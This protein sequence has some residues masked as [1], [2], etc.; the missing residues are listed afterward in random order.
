MTTWGLR[1]YDSGYKSFSGS[2]VLSPNVWTWILFE[3]DSSANT[4]RVWVNGVSGGTVAYVNRAF[5]GDTRIGGSVSGGSWLQARLAA[6]AART[7]A[8]LTSAEKASLSKAIVTKY[9]TFGLSRG[10]LV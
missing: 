4:W 6:V 9:P 1:V 5:G 2:P 7:G 10:V 3:A 8:I